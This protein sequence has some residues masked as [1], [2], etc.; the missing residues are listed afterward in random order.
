MSD[1]FGRRQPLEGRVREPHSYAASTTPPFHRSW[2]LKRLDLLAR[3]RCSSP[4]MTQTSL[5]APFHPASAIDFLPPEQLREVQFA[6]LKQ[7]VERAY[8]SVTLFHN[9]MDQ[10]GLTPAAIQSLDD[11]VKLPFTV[12]TDLRDAYPFGLFASPLQEIV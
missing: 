11:L 12:K 5:S 3:S 1:S 7:M 2:P 4:V 10:R 8:Q 9:R 6:R